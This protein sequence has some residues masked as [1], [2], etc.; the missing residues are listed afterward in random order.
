VKLLPVNVSEFE[1]LRE[2]LK[3][4]VAGD[5]IVIWL[6]GPIAVIVAPEGMP[7]PL[8]VW[9]MLRPTVL[10]TAM[11]LCPLCT[12]APG[13]EVLDV[14]LLVRLNVG[15]TVLD[16]VPHHMV[17]ACSGC[18][19]CTKAMSRVMNHPSRKRFRRSVF[20]GFKGR[21]GFR[22]KGERKGV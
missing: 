6:P 21:E 4:C 18:V 2:P 7:V 9:P 14:L 12:T 3:F 10:V 16:W 19:T 8:T 22:E 15:V 11:M 13:I 1:A 17:A 20:I 5:E